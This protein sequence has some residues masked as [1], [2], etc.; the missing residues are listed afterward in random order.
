MTYD[1]GMLAEN[2][3]YYWRIDERD[4]AGAAHTGPVWSFTTIGPGIGVKAQYF[5]GIDLAGTPV[6]TKTEDSINHTWGDSEVAGGLADAVSARW[7]ADL[8]AP[9]T[10]TV[11]LITT[12]DDGVRLWLN[13]RQVIDNWTPHGSADD[14][15][16]VHLVA[17]QFYRIKMEWFENSGS[18]L[19]Q[20]SWRSPSIARQ[21]IPAGV[22]QLPVHAANPYPAQSS[23]NAPET[24]VLRW[25]AGESAAQHD[26]Y[27]GTD[28]KAV[29]GA[30]PTTAG[31]YQGRQDAAS[32]TFDPGQLERNTT[33]YWR[34]DEVN[35]AEADSPWAGSLWSFTTADFLVVDDFEAYTDDE[36]SRIYEA[37]LDDYAAGA[38]GSTVGYMVAPFAEQTIVHAGSQSMPLD[39]NNV[40]SPYYS[41]AEREFAAAQNWTV[42]GVQTL[43]VHVRGKASNAA[44]PLYVEIQDSA[45]KL[46]AVRHP[47]IAV[48]QTT[49][50]TRW[51][52]PLSQFTASGVSVTKVKKIHIRVGDSAQ[53][54]SPGRGMIFVDDI[55]VVKP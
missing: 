48:V 4:S 28:A 6:A 25:I 42:G 36:G 52:I 47:N 19:A 29:A 50:W 35:E 37:W 38:C 3:T 24:A 1:P 23:V 32:T 9:F 16:T 21:I 14:I 15:A 22:L 45:G 43:V 5:S 20:L 49:T 8:E 51:E 18:A 7:T 26:V 44:A 13:G 33:Y 40:C 41:E 27:F 34:V 54:A 10:E 39:Y 11:D 17:G 46:G 53:A 2:T 31:I 30:D 12:T 55:W